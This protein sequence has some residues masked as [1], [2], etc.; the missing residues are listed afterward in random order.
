MQWGLRRLRSNNYKI[1]EMLAKPG[2]GGSIIMINLQ[3]YIE[4]MRLGA[5]GEEGKSRVVSANQ[6]SG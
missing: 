5:G 3:L 6:S 2:D 1:T 4:I